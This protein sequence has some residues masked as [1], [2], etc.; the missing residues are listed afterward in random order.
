M[1]GLVGILA[2]LQVSGISEGNGENNEWDKGT[3][4]LSHAPYRNTPL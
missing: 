1:I 4:S 2:L 3:G